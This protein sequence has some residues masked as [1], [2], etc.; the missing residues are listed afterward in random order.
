[1]KI[2]KLLKEVGAMLKLLQDFRRALE[3]NREHG[4]KGFTLIELLIVIAI[5][6]ILASM[7]IPSYIRYQQKAKV[8]SYAEPIARSCLMDIVSYCMD[9]PGESVNATL[10]TNCKGNSY[11]YTVQVT[12]SKNN[13]KNETRTVYGLFATPDNSIVARYYD[14]ASDVKSTGTTDIECT[15]DGQPKDKNGDIVDVTVGLADA[16]NNKTVGW[17]S[18]YY[19]Q[20]SYIEDRGIKCT[21]TD[22]PKDN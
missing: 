21:V 9:H 4:K 16:S 7:A 3:L 1:L 5:I 13:T 15:V 14:N 10:L 17:V 22:N 11:S 8:A 18:K 12:D 20:C 6:A 19:A 2:I